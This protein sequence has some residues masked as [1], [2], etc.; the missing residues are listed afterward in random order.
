MSLSVSSTWQWLARANRNPFKL[1]E[2]YGG[3]FNCIELIKPWILPLG[4]L[5]WIF[6]NTI[7]I[8]TLSVAVFP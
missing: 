7:H 8:L 5:W 2:E 6:T 3:Y 1:A 4:M